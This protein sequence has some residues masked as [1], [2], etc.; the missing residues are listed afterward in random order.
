MSKPRFLA[1]HDV[2]ERIL[3]GV[4]RREPLIDVARVRDFGLREANDGEV[5]TFADENDWLL[6][7]HDVNTM[8]AAAHQRVASGA[9]HAGLL[10]A[11]QSA[12]IRDVIFSLVLIWSA[13]E[14][15]QWRDQ[16]AFLPI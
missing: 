7:S 15:E 3:A 12:A 11:P 10:M 14:F 1:D 16:V 2:N 6:I 13:T 5:L 9:G 8:I 4:E